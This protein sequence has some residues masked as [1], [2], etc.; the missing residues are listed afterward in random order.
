[1]VRVGRLSA[2]SK[3]TRSVCS[4]VKSKRRLV[5][6]PSASEARGNGSFAVTT[7][8]AASDAPRRVLA[9]PVGGVLRGLLRGLLRVR[10]GTPGARHRRGRGRGR[11]GVP[12]GGVAAVATGQ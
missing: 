10:R 1:M 2:P 4:P 5:V 6:A 3:L 8:C 11:G 12:L 7:S 9:G